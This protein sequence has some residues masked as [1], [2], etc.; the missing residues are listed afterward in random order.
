MV[1]KEEEG[2][3]KLVLLVVIGLY[4]LAIDLLL[5][6]TGSGSYHCMNRPDSEQTGALMA[7]VYGRCIHYLNKSD[8]CNITLGM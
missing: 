4:S 7:P 8:H 2:E 1:V 3:D 5:V 6:I